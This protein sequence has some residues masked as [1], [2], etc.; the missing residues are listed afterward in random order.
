MCIYI[1]EGIDFPCEGN[2]HIS[3]ISNIHIAHGLL[4]LQKELVLKEIQIYLGINSN[5]INK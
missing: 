1:V 2:S 4:L 3:F 5:N